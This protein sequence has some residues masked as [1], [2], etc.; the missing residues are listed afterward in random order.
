MCQLLSGTVEDANI[1][2]GEDGK[3]ETKAYLQ[4]DF[5]FLSYI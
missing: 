2:Q 4:P 3:E 1:P 5:T